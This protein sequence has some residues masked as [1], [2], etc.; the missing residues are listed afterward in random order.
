MEAQ[1]LEGTITIFIFLLK[2]LLELGPIVE[3]L[4]YLS[5]IAMRK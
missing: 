1:I 4:G 3:E 2:P 5:D